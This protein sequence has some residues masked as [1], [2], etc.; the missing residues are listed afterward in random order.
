MSLL[1]HTTHPPGITHTT[2]AGDIQIFPHFEEKG[3]VVVDTYCT[4]FLSISR[5]RHCR[6]RFYLFFKNNLRIMS[7]VPAILS[8]MSVEKAFSN[9]NLPIEL[10][11]AEGIFASAVLIYLPHML[12]LIFGKFNNVEPRNVHN[13]GVAAR[14]LAAHQNQLEV[15]SFDR[16]P[17]CPPTIVAL[18]SSHVVNVSTPIIIS[19]NP[20]RRSIFRPFLKLPSPS[21]SPHKWESAKA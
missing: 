15:S 20:I 13:T 5:R 4:Y 8:F 6:S 14:A 2:T 17:P 16:L 3:V 21:S 11:A 19:Q 18:E 10:S 1:N 9:V 12:K 7:I